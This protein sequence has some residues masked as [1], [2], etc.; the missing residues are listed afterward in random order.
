MRIV[1]LSQYFDE[2]LPPEQ[3]SIGIVTYEI[4][5][6]LAADADVTVLSRAAR[7][8]PRRSIVGGAVF[9]RLA[10]APPRVWT[11]ASRVC[12]RLLPASRPL[13]V[14]GIYAL[15]YILLAMRRIRQL[16]PDVIHVQ[17]LPQHLPMIRRAAPD[18]A[19]VLHMHCDWLAQFDRRA[20]A[21]AVAAADMVVGCSQHVVQTA[22]GRHA[23]AGVS[24]AVLP[25]GVDVSEPQPTQHRDPQRVVF[26][27]RVSAEKG[28][29]TL[30][31]AWPSVVKL[32]PGAR[33]EIIG[34]AAETPR[35]LLIDLSDD[36]QVLDLARFYP[37]GAAF[38]GSYAAA[39]R[40]MIPDAVAHT[41]TFTGHLPHAR[42]QQRIAGAGLLVNPSLSESFGMSL[43]EALRVGTPAVATRVG[44][45][46]EIIETAGAGALVPMN[47][48]VALAAAISDVLATPA[49]SAEA[50]RA[51]AERVSERYSWPHIADL[52]RRLHLEALAARA[53]RQGEWR[54]PR[55]FLKNV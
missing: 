30:L 20:M 15:D 53:A 8:E 11:H 14:Q 24:F 4:A 10:C 43:I 37:G 44:G 41:V 45:M 39:L 21:R 26:V 12:Q 5:R 9:E 51:A 29:H 19:I 42:V 50:A 55:P 22:L 40:A 36:R 38:K 47:D 1:F 18:A 6:R 7:G 46:P 54:E 52:T 16:A 2:V 33:L 25:N 32:H 23:G 34:P 48:P 3:N 17:N 49:A 13:Y 35:Q 27:G 31:D 28:L